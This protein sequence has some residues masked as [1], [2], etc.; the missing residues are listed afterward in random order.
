[1]GQP[2]AQPAVHAV[3]EILADARLV[4]LGEATAEVAHAALVREWPGLREWLNHDREWLR[5]QR[6]LDRA[7]EEWEQSE[8]T[9]APCTAAPGR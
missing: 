3:L 7:A 8:G 4:T 6:Q 2:D 5:L 9:H 1:M